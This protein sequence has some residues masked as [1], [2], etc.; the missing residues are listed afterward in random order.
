MLTEEALILVG[1]LV[2][3]GLLV[4]GIW[5]LLSPSTQSLRRAPPVAMR[6]K[7]VAAVA[8]PM[9]EPELAEVVSE[10]P[11]VSESP[12]EPEPAT[13]A[14]FA[15]FEITPAAAPGPAADQ[16][17]IVD[18]CRSLIV[19][20]RFEDAVSTAMVVLEQPGTVPAPA[21]AALWQEVS[22]ARDRMGD[23]DGALTAFRE[24]VESAPGSETSRLRQECATW[25]AMT[26]R[27]MLA[28][29]PEE[30]DRYAPLAAARAF[31]GKAQEVIEG[32][33]ALEAVRADLDVDFWPAYETH[34]RT[35]IA[36]RDPA[37]A[38]RLATEALS[39]L[40]MPAVLRPT[41][42]EFRIETLAARIV[43]LAER[44]VL[45]VDE[46]REWE[47]V[48]ALERGETLLR[49]ASSL[50]ADRREDAANRLSAAYARL[51]GHRVDAGEFEDAVDPLLRS[52]RIS[53]VDTP[54]RDE[55]RSAMVRALQGVVETRVAMIRDVAATGNTE[56][57]AA[58]A[59]KV[60]TLLR[61]GIAAGVP[62]EPLNNAIATA[63]QLIE[64]FGGS[65]G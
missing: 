40:A 7:P 4:L 45:A 36:D 2:A 29:V 57:A 50:P 16:G 46:S 59:E 32:S 53:K 12:V 49:S 60:W 27:E 63:R 15:Q 28:G 9:P 64:E 26:A 39:D 14:P 35:L 55:A 51:G 34:V 24:A 43:V 22:I 13:E 54:E 56:S 31:V 42:E 48:G 61:T 17:W 19:D 62:Q 38:Y 37:E 25:A 3:S 21:T 65:T 47:A 33:A 1:L 18:R 23:R 52:L 11:T 30:G 58:Q 5:N 10:E 41:F 20:G 6:P 44:A 8:E